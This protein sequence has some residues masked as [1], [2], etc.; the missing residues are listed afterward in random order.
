ML[1]IF[2]FVDSV[3]GY[4]VRRRRCKGSQCDGYLALEG[5]WTAKVLVWLSVEGRLR[6]RMV[7]NKDDGENWTTVEY[8]S[9][10]RKSE[11]LVVKWRWQMNVSKHCQSLT[12]LPQ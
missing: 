9:K 11:G 7:K 6:T 1:L 2:V 4:M 10:V 5:F 8:M 3:G 12:L